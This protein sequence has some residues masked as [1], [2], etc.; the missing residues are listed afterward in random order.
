MQVQ[1]PGSNS[2]NYRAPIIEAVIDFDCDLPPETTLVEHKQSII[3][4][5]SELYPEFKVQ[6]VQ[7]FTLTPKQDTMEHRVTDNIAAYQCISAKKDQLIQFR[8]K[9]FSFNRL[10]PYTSLDEYLPEIERTWEIYRDILKPVFLKKISMRY[11]NRIE[12]PYS[13][14]D[15]VKLKDYFTVS[16]NI[17]SSEELQ[18]VGIFQSL[19]FQHPYNGSQAQ[20]TLA[21]EDAEAEFVPVVLDITAFSQIEEEPRSLEYLQDKIDILRILKNNIYETSLTPL[22]QNLFQQL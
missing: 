18:L 8:T 12:I 22:C 9:G 16:P 17:T 21:T 13:Q 6:R 20:L 14:N 3:E 19:R 2:E 5:T 11:I 4:A 10:S 1:S 7:E 15:R